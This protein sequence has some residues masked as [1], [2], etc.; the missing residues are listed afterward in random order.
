MSWPHIDSVVVKG[1]PLRAE[2]E[3]VQAGPTSMTSVVA[4]EQA[5]F[6]FCML[7]VDMQT[8]EQWNRHGPKCCLCCTCAC[9]LGIE[10]KC[11]SMV[12]HECIHC[13]KKAHFVGML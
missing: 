12:R 1:M 5:S 10:S 8:L 3:H 9:Q 2:V 11:Q 6:G 7:C 4:T 13:S